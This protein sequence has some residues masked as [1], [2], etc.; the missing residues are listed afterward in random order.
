MVITG[1]TNEY[2]TVI[3]MEDADD[4]IKKR[5]K[6]N[7]EDRQWFIDYA[8]D[9]LMGNTDEN[10]SLK[11]AYFNDVCSVKEV[12]EQGNVIPY[13]GEYEPDGR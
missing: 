13:N 6:G 2:G 11:E 9:A 4:Y 5:I 8:L 1:Y 12:D 3:P 7:K 10:V